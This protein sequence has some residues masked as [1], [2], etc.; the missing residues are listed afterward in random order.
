[1]KMSHHCLSLSIVA[2]LALS[3]F[4]Q[5]LPA[6]ADERFAI[7]ARAMLEA[8]R[9]PAVTPQVIAQLEERDREQGLAP[10]Y[11]IP[12][13]VDISP[14][15]HGDWA[16]VSESMM[17]WRLR[18][19]SENAV[20]LNFGFDRY[21]LPAGAQLYIYDT[22]GDLSIRPFTSA[23]NAAHG[24]LWT[25]P[26]VSNDVILEL[27]VPVKAVEQVD[28]HLASINAGYRTFSEVF[29]DRSGSCNV[30][31][32]CPEGDGWRAE[33]ASVAAIS[34][35]GSLFCSGFMVNNTAED[36]TPYFMTA[37]HCGISS[38]NAAS[39]V[40]FWNY[41]ATTCGGP[42]DGS[43]SQFQ[44]GS[45]FR[46]SKSSSDFTLVELDELPDPAWMV[47]YAGWDAGG[48]DAQW[49]CGIHHPSVDEKA[50]SFEWQPTTTTS[51]LG[52][53][54][55]GDG[56]HVRITDWDVGTTEPGSSGSPVFNQ[57]HRVIGQLHGGYAACGN[58]DSDW[59]GKFSVSWTGTASTNRLRDWLDEANTGATSVDT[60]WPG[61]SGIAVTPG[62]TY[63]AQGPSG[64]PFTPASQIYT[65]RNMSDV[66]LNYS[67]TSLASWLTIT[68]GSGSIAAG[69]SANVTVAINSGANSF[70]NGRYDATL[71]FVNTTDHDGDT[72]RP[73]TLFVGVPEQVYSWDMNTNPGWTTQGQWAWGTPTGGGG[74]YGNNDP[75]SG[76][77][78]TK[79]YGYNLAGDYA[80]SIPE[81]HLT[82]TAI[83][84]S[85][86]SRT[87][88]KFRRFLNVEQPAYDHAYVRVSN[89]G[90]NWTQVWT[91]GSEI[92]DA[93]WQ[94]VE[95]DISDVADG[96]S[97]V[98]VRWTMGATDSSW[99]YSG[100]NVDD[101]SIWGV[102]PSA[103]CVP[104]FN[105]D[106]TLDF[107]DVQAFLAAFSAHDPSADLTND[108]TFDFFDVLTYLNVFSA[109]C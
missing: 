73:V 30:D 3:A 55:P 9:A 78:G 100:W 80:N 11:A 26:T 20:S 12:N 2:G 89:N 67:V 105:D 109:G 50:I 37:N 77:T 98:Y 29:G 15:T 17:V 62:G 106:G 103:D 32:V 45:F 66:P 86:L 4:A 90:T 91:N 16:Q 92:T 40:C 107:F 23:D 33:I 85:N 52:T 95:Y 64:G 49:A 102:V 21:N 61:A 70:G 82:T 88:L 6:P 56:S 34:A 75:T 19:T 22:T 76:A 72:T 14:F 69:N 42:R 81:Y 68:N 58:N 10:R 104:D 99:Q 47:A 96:H 43:L 38:G 24:E 54:V 101:V 59:Y 8:F 84:C 63:T 7:E 57:D 28:L 5:D 1:M 53:S 18:V 25:P 60:L 41:Q 35:G 94:S 74:Q 27:S 48:A 51:Y 36:E 87:T 97:T 71:D 83:D 93:S 108:G 65:V 44:S 79:V 31:V 39:L 13:L 46:A